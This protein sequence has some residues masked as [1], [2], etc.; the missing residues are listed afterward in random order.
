MA[1][2]AAAPQTF[3]PFHHE[4][5]ALDALLTAHGAPAALRL[6]MRCACWNPKTGQPDA[7]CKVCFPYG[8]VW[9]AAQALKVFGPSR[10]GMR[11]YEIEGT[12]EVGDAWFTFP[13]GIRPSHYSR[14]VLTASEVT[15]DDLLTKGT[16]DRIRWSR[17]VA[18]E[19]AHYTRRV[20]T[21]GHP[22]EIELVPLV[23]DGAMP[24]LAVVGNQITWL[25]L[26]IPDGTRYTLRLRV[27][28]EYVIW[29]VQ[30]RNEAGVV[31]PYRFLAKR[32]DFLLHPRGEKAVSY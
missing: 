7:G 24:D 30:D 12:L 27:L 29:D 17:V 32:L 9:D 19:A 31:L 28:A 11:K 14:L 16:E 25:N 8:Y 10:R 3:R 4:P 2:L 20:P 18:A 21:T 13:V 15:V 1:V 6:A 23:L 26:S 22:Y 5:A